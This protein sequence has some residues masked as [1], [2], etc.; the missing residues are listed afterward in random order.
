MA[1]EACFSRAAYLPLLDSQDH[2][3]SILGAPDAPRSET[4][5][6]AAEITRLHREDRELRSRHAAERRELRAAIATY[7]NQI[8]AL[9]LRVAELEQANASMRTRLQQS[10]NAVGALLPPRGSGL[11]HAGRAEWADKSHQR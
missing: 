2:P 7:A 4:D 5:T 11:D 1:N 6:L 3:G 9:A 8:Q 10:D